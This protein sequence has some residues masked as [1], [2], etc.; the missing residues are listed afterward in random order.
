[1]R[2]L[3]QSFFNKLIN[4][5]RINECAIISIVGYEKNIWPMHMRASKT[6]TRGK[7]FIFFL[8]L[9]RKGK[10]PQMID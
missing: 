8:F 10:L 7:S 6:G 4:F 5:L 3:R 2:P 1:M 9:Q